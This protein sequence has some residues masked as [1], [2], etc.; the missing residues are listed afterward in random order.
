MPNNFL[1]KIVAVAT[2]VTVSVWLM[3]PG[4]AQAITIAELKAQIAAIQEQI[5]ALQAQ[6]VEL[7]SG[8]TAA[9]EGVPA[10]FTFE[11]NLRQ[12]D[13]GDEVKYLQIVL[14]SDPDTKLADSGVGSPGNETTYFGP[15]TKAAVVKFQEKYADEVLASWG[16]TSGT[17]FVG[18]TTRAKLNSLLGVTPAEEEEVPA[19]EEEVVGEN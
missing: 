2:T 7:Q 1:K 10:G 13:S 16:F 8:E 3:G 12:G 6:L 17:G 5:A 18:P 14:N 11:N 15:L 9:I 4:M 19:E